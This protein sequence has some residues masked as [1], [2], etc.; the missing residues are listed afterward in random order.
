MEAYREECFKMSMTKYLDEKGNEL[1]KTM[2][3]KNQIDHVRIQKW[4]ALYISKFFDVVQWWK[5]HE[6]TYPELAVAA[7]ITLGKPTHNA[8]QERVFS[9]GTYTDT[10]LRKRLKEE[11]FEMSVL[12][13]VNG[14]EIDEVYELMKPVLITKEKERIKFMKDF[15]KNR[16][17][18][19][20][21][22]KIETNEDN[23]TEDEI[24]D[25]KPKA[26][27]DY[28]SVCSENTRDMYSDIDSDDDMDDEKEIENEIMS[29]SVNSK[30]K[31]V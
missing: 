18:E 22:T 5:D 17:E 7:T 11:H 30:I 16:N 25:E 4:D 28:A 26:Q 20:D 6:G 12:N 2:L 3:E 19:E 9:R 13:A 24:D 31:Q 10:K 15:I 21:L 14:K 29:V 23:E 8:F 1:Y 27:P